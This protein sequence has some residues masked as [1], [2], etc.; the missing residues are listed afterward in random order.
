MDE[1]AERIR[2]GRE[3]PGAEQVDAGVRA[4]AS[5]G[6]GKGKAAK[7][8]GAEIFIV[9]TNKDGTSRRKGVRVSVCEE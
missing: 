7:C 4:A 3:R 1:N 6:Q 9:S 8:S 5:A 2:E